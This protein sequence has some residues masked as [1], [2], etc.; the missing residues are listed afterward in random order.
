[1]TGKGRRAVF[2]DRDGVIN[3]VVMRSGK[4]CSPRSMDEF[5]L[6]DGVEEAIVRLKEH[7]FIIIVVTN[8]PDIARK[9]ITLDSLN[10]MLDRIYSELQIDAVWICPHDDIDGCNCRKPKAGMLIEAAEKWGID[11]GCS[12]IIGDSWKDMEAGKTAGCATILLDRWYN[13]GVMCD[14]QTRNLEEAVKIIVPG[15]P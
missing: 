14:Y 10:V 12:F 11:L 13:Q 5:K 3:K 9:K 2:L 4:P 1:M 15:K 7:F 8:Q 6:E